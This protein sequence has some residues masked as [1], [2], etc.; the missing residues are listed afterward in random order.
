MS[1]STWTPAAL[2]SNARAL[3]GLCWRM[4]EAQHHVSTLKLVDT[5]PEQAILESLIDGA[6]PRVSASELSSV[7]AIS[8]WRISYRITI[9]S[10]RLDRRCVLWRRSAEDRRSRDGD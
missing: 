3:F 2:S 4:V 1:S 7:H 10:R 6:K 9:S 8:I 5:L